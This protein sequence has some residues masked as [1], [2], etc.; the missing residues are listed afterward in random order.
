MVLLLS[1]TGWRFL[2]SEVPL[3]PPLA[4]DCRHSQRCGPRPADS[5]YQSTFDFVYVYAVPWSEFPSS[6]HTL[7]YEVP[8]SEFPIV[9][10]YPHYP[11]TC[12]LTYLHTQ[13]AVYLSG[14][15]D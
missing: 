9:P 6:P 10:S 1:L 4:A 15:R 13:L 11:H 7:I 12:R 8:W 5:Q 3:Y 14:R 2:I